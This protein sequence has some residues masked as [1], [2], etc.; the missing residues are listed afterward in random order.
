VTRPYHA[1]RHAEFRRVWLSQLVSQVGSQMQSVA[2][3]WHVYLLTG[4]PLALGAMGLTRALPTALFSLWGGVVAD[5]RDRRLVMLAAQSGM[6][7]VALALA[8]LTL[9]GRETLLALY[10]LNALGAAAG[11]FDNPSRQALIPRLVPLSSLPG[12]LAMN[13]AMFQTALI[14]GPALAGLLIAGH[15]A[16]GLAGA[17][18]AGAATSGTGAIAMIYAINAVSFLGVLGVLATLRTSGQVEAPAGGVHEPPLAALR[19]GLRFVLTTPVMVWSTGLDFVATFFA[20]AMSLLPI[21]ADKLL[22]VGPAGYGALVAAPAAGALLGSLYTAARPLPERQGRLL[23]ASIAAYGLATV[24]FGLSRSYALT[25]VA[26]AATGLADLVSTVIRQTL[27]QLLTPDRLRG[28]M[29]GVNMMFF[30]GG[31]QLGEV[32]AGLVASLFASAVTGVTVSIVFGGVMTLLAAA[33]VA[34]ATPVIRD[35]AQSPLRRSLPNSQA[36][37]TPSP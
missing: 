7:L 8:A 5:R 4:S 29:T 34:A 31:P 14:G 9:S 27:R 23:L 6:T 18:S 35:Y 26:L 16:S 15:A 28:R 20:G 2:L 37:S 1:L 30:I 24:V 32:E 19:E 21:V 17:A 11:A 22:H 13:L 36:T 10:L 3:H 25:L 12:A 33:V